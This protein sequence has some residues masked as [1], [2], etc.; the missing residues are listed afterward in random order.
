L[1]QKF[2]SLLKSLPGPSQDFVEGRAGFFHFAP[3]DVSTRQKTP[4]KIVDFMENFYGVL[5]A[6]MIHLN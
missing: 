1:N 4:R 2:F 3:D 5:A 6:D